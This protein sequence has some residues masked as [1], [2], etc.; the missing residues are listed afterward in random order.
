MNERELFRIMMM[1]AERKMVEREYP[2]YLKQFEQ[3]SKNTKPQPQEKDTEE[4]GQD[5]KSITPIQVADVVHAG[6]KLIVPD[7][8]EIP[9]AIDLLQRR[10]KYLTERVN[11]TETFNVFP[12]DGAVALDAVLTEMYGWAPAEATGFWGMNPP[13][14]VDV[15]V[16]FQKHKKV[17]W[18]AFGLPNVDGR[19][20]CDTELK[21]GTY[22]FKIVATAT[23][24]DQQTLEKLFENLRAYLRTNSIYRGQAIKIRFNNDDGKVLAMPEPTFLETGGISEADLIYPAEVQVAIETNLFTPISRVADCMLNDIPV[25]RGVLL[26]GTFG[27]GKTLAAKMASK[28]AVDA[29]LTYIYVPRADE[30]SLAIAFAMQYQNPA[31]VLFCEDID[32]AVSGER[33][34]EMD[35]LLNI[36]DGIDSKGAH[37]ITV[38]TT[39]DLKAINPAMLRPGRLDAVIEITPPDA[40]AVERL[41]RL[42]GGASIAMD[43]DLSEAAAKLHGA[44]PAVVA[45]VVKRAKLAQLRLE[46][47][48]QKIAMLSSAALV[49]AASTMAMQ[50]SLL[51]PK[52]VVDAAPSF[53]QMI[54]DA[55]KTGLNGTIEAVHETRKMTDQIRDAVV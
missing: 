5:L 18:G 53:S 45:E 9:Q 28:L 23:R 19:I 7:G 8:M 3:P 1:L 34:V 11:I 55:V 33:S 37:L 35:D 40:A 29:G 50:L 17:A 48:G 32:R 24:K 4:M 38:L 39:N 44:I 26:G 43:L 52:A 15:Q 47:P 27:T 22:R 10:A 21:N 36:I 13:T 6:E 46:A 12:W 51:Y 42:Y 25:K 49:E 16:G 41:L 14:L 30:L 2:T 20:H 54:T 31:A